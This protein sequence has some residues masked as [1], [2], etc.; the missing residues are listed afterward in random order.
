MQQSQTIPRQAVVLNEKVLLRERNRRTIRRVASARYAALSNGW[1]G[2]GNSGT[3]PTIQ[4]WWG[5]PP[6]STPGW[7]VPWF[8]PHHPD[9]AGGGTLGTP[10]PSR[11][12]QGDPRYP[13]PS[14]PGQGGPWVP[15]T[16]Q[17]CPEGYLRVPPHP[18]LGWVTPPSRPGM[19]YPRPDLG[20]GTPPPTDLGQGTPLT[21]PG[22]GC[23]PPRSG[24]GYPPPRKCEQT[25]NITFPH[26]SD[27]GGKYESQI[28]LILFFFSRM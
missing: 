5:Y 7:G 11:P 26:P 23:P 22:T 19:G 14:R 28:S 16:I 25:E 9:L 1:V 6:P 13:P 8:T 10:P 21:K 4:T 17:T 27:A 24:M 12:G 2:G 15:P 20:W 3:P 18:D